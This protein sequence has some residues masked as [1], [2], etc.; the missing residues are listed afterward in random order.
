M[1]TQAEYDKTRF[2]KNKAKIVNFKVGD[3]VLLNKEDRHQIKL[4]P[5]FKGPFEIIEVLDGDRY[6]LTELTGRIVRTPAPVK[7]SVYFLISNE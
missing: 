5:K 1:E 6:E 3:H 4:D 7:L 2:Y